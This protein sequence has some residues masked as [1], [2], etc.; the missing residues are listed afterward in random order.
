MT[1]PQDLELPILP[2][3]PAILAVLAHLSSYLGCAGLAGHASRAGHCSI[4]CVPPNAKKLRL[5]VTVQEVLR[6][7]NITGPLGRSNKVK[8][9]NKCRDC[10]YFYDG[11]K[12]FRTEPRSWIF[13]VN[14][15]ALGWCKDGD[16]AT[17]RMRTSLAYDPH[18][19]IYKTDC[20]Y[21]K[22]KA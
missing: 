18:R 1:P 10:K 3:L 5:L 22:R 11:P 21:F 19:E 2:I 17:E 15:Q 7:I 16:A 8:T 6:L 9:M 13:I 12:E 4:S 20:S 14:N